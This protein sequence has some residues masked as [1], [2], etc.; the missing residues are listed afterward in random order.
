MEKGFPLLSECPMP[1]LSEPN[2]LFEA[3]IIQEHHY[4]DLEK[5][6]ASADP[7][8]INTRVDNLV[9]AF[10]IRGPLNKNI[11][12]RALNAVARLHPILTA[13]FYKR[14]SKLYLQVKPG[15][16]L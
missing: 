3:T 15:Q 2:A 11:L 8:G 4:V 14:K 16:T 13:R 10:E 5:F 1:I 9:R 7:S 12:E 6:A